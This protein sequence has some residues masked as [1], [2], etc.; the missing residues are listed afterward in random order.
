MF[1]FFCCCDVAPVF[2]EVSLALFHI[3]LYCCF[4]NV[5]ITAETMPRFFFLLSAS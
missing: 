3:P 5:L 4:D 1:V 2:S